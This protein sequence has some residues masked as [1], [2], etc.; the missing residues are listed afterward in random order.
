MNQF[1]R[2]MYGRYGLDQFAQFTI[3]TSMIISL[4]ASL[5]KMNEIIYLSY[6]LF[7]YTIFRI[8][9]KNISKRTKE[10]FIFLKLINTVKHAFQTRKSTTQGSNTYKFYKCPKC[11]Q[12][13]RVPKGKGKIC[14][15]CPK[16]KIEF[17]KRT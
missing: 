9:S 1:R 6:P 17:V 15:T 12:T 5:S 3:W 14:I 16:C 7:F 4:I 11:K 13:I 8:L 2:F 10:N